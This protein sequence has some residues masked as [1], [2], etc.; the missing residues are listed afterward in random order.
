MKFK[1]K[2]IILWP[3]DSE[4]SI[5]EVEF[6]SDKVNVITG[7]SGKGKSTILDIIDYCLGSSKC[8]IPTGLIRDLTEWFGILIESKKKNILLARRVPSSGSGDMFIDEGKKVIIPNEVE[9]NCNVRDV[10]SL[11][12]QY[13]GLTNIDFSFSEN[14]EGYKS[15]PSVRDLVSL[16]FQP[17]HIIANSYILFYKAD[18][19]EHRERLKT[20]FPYV[21][22]VIDDETLE[23]KEELKILRKQKQRLEVE[24]KKRVASVEVWI[25]E[26]RSYYFLAQS[27]GLIPDSPEKLDNLDDY[28]FY[29]KEAA[30]F[31]ENNQIPQI[32]I[33]VTKKI[34]NRVSI[35]TNR[36]NDTAFQIQ[37]IQ[38][39][40]IGVRNISKTN[41]EYG[42]ALLTQE[43]RTKSAGWFSKALKDSSVCQFCGSGNDNSKTYASQ[44]H[45]IHNE[46]KEMTY[47]VG[48]FQK[49]F[50]R[51]IKLMESTLKELEEKLNETRTELKNL[52]LSN[53]EFNKHRQTL[54][55][56]YKFVGNLEEALKNF[57]MAS[58]NSDLSKKIKSLDDRILEINGK[59]NQTKIKE[60][61]ANAIA[62]I[63]KLISFYAKIFDAER[64]NS[65]IK[66][67]ITNL[68][69][70]FVNKELQ[71]DFLWEIG[72]GHNHMAYHIS[73]ILALHEYLYKLGEKNKTPQFLVVDQ[74]S[75]VYFP[76]LNDQMDLTDHDDV[77]RV[78]KIF[79]AFSEF[80]KRTK[81]NVQV[82]VLE[83]AGENSWKKF[84][85][86]KMIKRW[87][88]G[89]E[90]NGLIPENWI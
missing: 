74:P 54:N 64:Y 72:S 5:R 21:L 15:P 61:Q 6:D 81:S 87:R 32:E 86:V 89:E 80:N 62:K 31:A 83:H 36:E 22:G 34:A 1:I 82:I 29:L 78:E 3:K 46:I 43:D 70:K 17:Q 14:R 27:Y 26:V 58:S 45:S 56:I 41:T 73:T 7:D 55:N 12:N 13:L 90:D 37:Q 8:A 84:D 47:K 65:V 79:K 51:E 28:I 48:D 53:K 76:E 49:V 23:L 67:D 75:Q 39:K 52:Y 71:S 44:V 42:T 35:L 50:N 20:I 4:K 16:T 63:G 40:L 68:A 77:E 38:E 66:L 60:K 11:L 25:A 10:K 59:I 88:Q 19:A 24:L 30:S 33:G 2:K 57:D 85:N 9:K 69:L 18:T